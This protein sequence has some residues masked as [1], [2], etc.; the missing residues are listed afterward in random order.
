MPGFGNDQNASQLV[1]GNNHL[2]VVAID[3]YKGPFSELSNCTK[4]GRALK[5]I[6]LKHYNF[7]EEHCLLMENEHAT[8][9]N[10]IIQ[11]NAYANSLTD[12]D[13]LMI[14]FAGH[15][16][17]DK[18]S[19][20]GY[21][22][23]HEITDEVLG[24]QN[25]IV[26]DLLKPELIKV[27]HILLV[28]DSCFSGSF[29]RTRAPEKK[30]TNDPLESF[31]W[32]RSR[33]IATSGDMEP[34]DDGQGHSPFARAIFTF[35]N[36]FSDRGF[37]ASEMLYAVREIMLGHK[38][39]KPRFAPVPALGDEGGEFVFY[40][41][42]T[43]NS[44]QT[45]FDAL[46]PL[47]SK[48]AIVQFIEAYP[49][50]HLRDQALQLLS[51]L[52]D[53]EAWGIATKKDL[54]SAYQRY[55]LK[56]PTGKYCEEARR[57]TEEQLTTSVEYTKTLHY[58]GQTI[59]DSLLRQEEQGPPLVFVEGGTF[60]M[61]DEN[62]E[63]DEI[64]VHKV[65]LSSFAIGKYPLTVE[66][67][68]IYCVLNGIKYPGKYKREFSDF[69]VSFLCWYDTV[70]YCQWLSEATGKTYRLPT[71]AEWEFA[72][73]GGVLSRFYDFA[74]S[75]LLHEVGWYNDRRMEAETHQVGR[76]RPN[77]LGIHDM[78]GNV[79]EWCADWY[80]ATWYQELATRQTPKNPAG[81]DTGDFKVLRGGSFKS[82]RNACRVANRFY[83]IPEGAIAG[84]GVRVV[85]EIE[86]EN[87]PRL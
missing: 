45:K 54:P 46:A 41:L 49:D 59:Q 42:E 67:Y 19:E 81:P 80:S 68:H 31:E 76:L 48:R 27:R 6:L 56:F 38:Y 36:Q 12:N 70:R 4:D 23:T 20:K 62:G 52:E 5:E 2:F 16:G 73:K 3:K 50:S 63:D 26:L 37:P 11:L 13:N 83:M 35:L 9:D 82:D 14:Y 22:I 28:S 61:G 34:V 84:L 69:P 55:L 85:R 72:A 33:W 66:D 77:E 74:G 1:R 30:L 18:R 40:R 43:P 25:E 29:F 15:G 58:N 44:I 7:K 32:R 86:K 53:E 78:C 24:L 71:E 75:P 87:H 60:R 17:V 64:P 39:Q 8:R 65:R 79:W 57:L 10:I 51:D 47:K 21:W